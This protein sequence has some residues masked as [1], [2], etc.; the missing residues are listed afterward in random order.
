MKELGTTGKLHS[1]LFIFQSYSI[2]L[3]RGNAFMCFG[4]TCHFGSGVCRFVAKNLQTQ[5]IFIQF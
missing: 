1:E 3:Q 4:C 2:D 5:T